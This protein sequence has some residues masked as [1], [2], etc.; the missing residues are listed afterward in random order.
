M[1]RLAVASC[2][3]ALLALAGCSNMARQ[4]AAVVAGAPADATQPVGLHA[5][6]QRPRQG[7]VRVKP[8]RQEALQEAIQAY[9]KTHRL[10][11]G[12]SLQAGA[13]LDGD[14]KAEAVVLLEGGRACGGGGCRL[15]VFALRE[16]VYKPMAAVR[17]VRLPVVM[18]AKASAGGWHDL[19]VGSGRID[20]S[21]VR[22]RL[23]YG[24]RG[25][26]GN[27]AAAP[28]E[29]KEGIGISLLALADKR[30]A[31]PVA[32]TPARAPSRQP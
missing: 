23:S 1:R 21:S 9:R 7:P 32:A 24:P 27:A 8:L 20:G 11:Q 26:P 2:A 12:S 31:Q 18:R 28:V 16:G 3:I 30:R 10:G 15:I 17:N 5:M 6:R 19:V 22:R 13:D 25:Y 14:G 4:P 29:G